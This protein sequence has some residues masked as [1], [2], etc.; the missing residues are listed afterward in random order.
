MTGNA[1]FLHGKPK[2]SNTLAG[3]GVVVADR[4]KIRNRLLSRLSEDAF[5][6]IAAELEPIEL[7]R[8]FEFSN[9]DTPA[10]HAYFI[11]AGIGSIVAITPEGQRS[12]VG[13]FGPDG[14]SPASL[15]LDTTATPYSIFMQ[16]PGHGLRIRSETLRRIA[17]RNENLRHLLSRYA[18]VLS[19]Q[20]SYTGLSNS[21]HHI[22]ERLAR[23]ILMC[24]DRTSG[25]RIALTHEF[26]SVMLAVRRSSVTTALHV[27]EGKHLVYS[28]RNLITVRD[29]RALELFAGDAYGVPEREYERLLGPMR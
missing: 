19:V 3:L 27:L 26:L 4:E 13:I 8:A 11:E 1:L 7:P 24:H 6:L 17:L 29:R 16:I 15:V 12:E 22:D 28:E 18:Y 20:T 21:V 23:W 25:D 2:D 9:P 14:M 5:Q 10:D